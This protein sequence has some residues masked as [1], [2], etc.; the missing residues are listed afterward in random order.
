VRVYLGTPGFEAA[1]DP[2][3]PVLAPGV[4]AAADEPRASD[5]IFARQVL[6]DARDVRGGSVRLLAESAYAVVERPIDDHSGPFV[7]HGITPADLH[8][9]SEPDGALGSR[10]A[11]VERAL[12]DLLKERRRRA[13]RRYRPVAQT[14]MDVSFDGSGLVV[15]L[16]ALARDRILVSVAAPRALPR[17]GF[18]LAPWPAGRAPVAIDRTLPSRAYQKVEEAWAWMGA[19]PAPG[20]LCV[21]LGAA[22]GGWT[23]AALK[24]GARVVAVDR[25]PLA[26]TSPRLATIVGNAF[27]Y[28]PAAPA[29]WLISDVICEPPRSLGLID[30]WLANAWCRNLVVTVKFKGHA[31]YGVLSALDPIFDRARPAFARVKHL[32]FNKNEVC[33]MVK[34]AP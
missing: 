14:T 15:Q 29:D 25:A 32:A 6:P 33:V 5:P 22:P 9:E 23:A 11:L 8:P 24:R 34:R 19:A 2:K 7:V 13:S 30:A 31:G 28:A 18:D 3:G 1:I 4:V 12:L 10:V 26:L 16:L 17:G 20:Q 27:T 21:D